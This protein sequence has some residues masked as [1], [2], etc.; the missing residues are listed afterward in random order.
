MSA[1]LPP[2]PRRHS[3]PPAAFEAEEVAFDL[4]A[5]LERIGHHGGLDP[6]VD[7]LRAVHAAHA[8]TV[9]FENLDIQLGRPI[10]LDLAS[11]QAKLV[12]QRRGGYCFEQNHVL[13]AALRTIGFEVTPLSAR[14]RLGATGP[15]PRTHMLLRVDV[16]GR[17][18]IADVGFG[19]DGLIEPIPLEEDAAVDQHGWRYRLVPEAGRLLVLQTMRPEG[20]F[21]LYAFTLEPTP[22]VDYVVANHFTSTHPRSVFVRNVTAQLVGVDARVVLDNRELSEVGPDGASVRTVIE[23]DEELLLVL[24]ERFGLG[25][26]ARTR[27]RALAEGA[28]GPGSTITA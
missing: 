4:R 13:M 8:T 19:G 9:P 20:W 3:R 12:G 1:S 5:Y 27:F 22:F 16:E 2:L 21:D 23:D 28:D 24:L 15:T 11:L 18:W 7:T 10:R 17:P 26:P 6:T 14:V 25:F